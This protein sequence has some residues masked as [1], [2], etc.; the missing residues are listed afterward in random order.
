MQTLF[1]AVELALHRNIFAQKTEEGA[2]QICQKR[3]HFDHLRCERMLPAEGKKLGG[4]DGGAAG[5]T[6][7]FADVTGDLAF[8]A[9]LVEKQ[10][11]VAQDRGEEII[12]VVRH[13]AGELAERLHVW[14]PN[15]LLL[16]LLAR[17]HVHE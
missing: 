16:Q 8:H 2:L 10:I 14:R 1:A 6:S 3:V 5:G 17:G 12:E 11:A 9:N 4:E 7:N 13:S 15:E